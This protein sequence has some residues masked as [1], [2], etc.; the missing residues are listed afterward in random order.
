M[1]HHWNS[2]KHSKDM[3]CNKPTLSKEPLNQKD[4]YFCMNGVTGFNRKNKQSF[5]YT[6]VKTVEKPK[7]C[8]CNERNSDNFENDLKV[9]I[10]CNKVDKSRKNIE[11]E[12]NDSDEYSDES[13]H[14]ENDDDYIP[15]RGKDKVF[16]VTLQEKLNDLV[17]DLG[18]PKDSA[19]VF[20]PFMRKKITT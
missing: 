18:L 17:R 15:V 1:P 5:F 2:S 16:H 14:H 6:N 13:E 9:R 12:E 8:C 3:K 7:R 20:T 4:C 11:F 19:E 10:D